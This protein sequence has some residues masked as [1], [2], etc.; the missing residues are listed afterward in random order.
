M[1]IPVTT[2]IKQGDSLSPILFN[3]I[4]DEF[5]NEVK[6][7][8]RGY[9]MEDIKIMYYADDAVLISENKDK[10]QKL[11]L[12]LEQTAKRMNMKI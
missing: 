12:R 3:I 8:G 6:K 7:T 1:K 10:L 5:T 2:G 4:T 9:R 11:H